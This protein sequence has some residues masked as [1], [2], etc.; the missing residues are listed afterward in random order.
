MMLIA[1]KPMMTTAASATST[2]GDFRPLFNAITFA[3]DSDVRPPEVQHAGH[4]P[5]FPLR[6]AP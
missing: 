1:T 5:S 3:S 4:P 6:L 2:H